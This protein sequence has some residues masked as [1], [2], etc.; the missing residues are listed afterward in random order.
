MRQ[1]W[2]VVL[3]LVACVNFASASTTSKPIALNTIRNEFPLKRLLRADSAYDEKSEE[4]VV[5]VSGIAGAMMPKASII[6]E[7]AKLKWWLATRKSATQVFKLLKID[8]AI[9]DVLTNS[10]MNVLAKYISMYNNK[11]P[12]NQVSMVGVLSTRYGGEAAVARMLVSAKKSEATTHLA[13]KLQAEQVAGW[14]KSEKSA[15]DVF[16]ILMLDDAGA[17]PLS[18]PGL[19]AWLNYMSEFNR[20]N[21][22]KE[23]TMLQTFTRAYGGDTGVAKLLYASKKMYGSEIMADKLETALFVKWAKEGLTPGRVT[24]NVLNLRD[25]NWSQTVFA[26]MLER[27]Q[28]FFR[29]KVD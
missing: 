16:R 25:S 28:A 10:N 13:T 24:T 2:I 9:N 20:L 4:R 17:Y 23:T 3:T 15:D 1:Y 6:N 19:R 22:G 14:L 26:P 8:D 21:P 27:Y 18:S 7:S 12:S 11:N 29:K 5:G